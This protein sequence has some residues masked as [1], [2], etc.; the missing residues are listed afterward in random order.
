MSPSEIVWELISS[1]FQ[2]TE[3]WPAVVLCGVIVFGTFSLLSRFKQRRYQL[4]FLTAALGLIAT[5]F[6]LLMQWN[7]CW[8]YLL[9]AAL[10]LASLLL[11][12]VPFFWN[13][14]RFSKI[15]TLCR[16][17]FFAEAWKYLN[18]IRVTWLTSKQLRHY[19]QRRFFLLLKLGSLRTARNYLEEIFPEKGTNYHFFL[20]MLEYCSGD[21]RASLQEIQAAED[22]VDS[23]TTPSF[24][25]QILM[26]H[27]VCYAA[28][29]QYHLADEYYRKAKT[30]YDNQKLSDE[31]LL[32]TFYYNFA[33][34]QLRLH[35]DTTDW[36]DALNECQRQ[37]NMRKTDAKIRMLNLRLELLCQTE[38]PREVMDQLLQKA[39]TE[40][41]KCRLRPQ[42]Q[43]FFA[44]SAVRVA[45][46][47]RCNPIPCLDILLD[48]LS[49]IEGLSPEQ[50]YHVYAGLDEVFRDF[51]GPSNHR[52]TPLKLRAESYMKTDAE[53]DLQQWQAALPMEAVY[54]RCD[55]L[56]KRAVFSRQRTEYD[57]EQVVSFQQNAIRLYHDNG[58]YLEELH[59]HQDVV[60]ELLDVRNRNED[61]RPVCMEEIREHLSAAEA[62]LNK[63]EGHPA[64]VVAYLRLGCYYLDVDAYEQSL[65][66]A[67][68]FWNTDISVQN[69]APW[70][71]R[72]YA[73]L[74]LHARVILFEQ[75]IREAAADQQLRAMDNEVQDWF[76]TYPKHDGML[77]SL[78]LGRFLT[79]PVRKTKCWLPDANR[80][81]QGHSWLWIPALELNI[82]ITYPQFSDDKLC[83]CIFFFKDRHPFEAETSLTLQ[84]SYQNSSL[85]FEGVI[86]SQIENV[87]PPQA[88]LV[89]TI[90]DFI[91]S[92]LPNDCPSAASFAQLFQ[93]F[94]LP[95]P[96]KA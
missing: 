41:T 81:V 38:A 10:I 77:D 32:G 2:E 37:L 94:L 69:F 21:L 95:V 61:Y 87:L 22:S 33:F 76:A 72:Y 28:M 25:F 26:N 59:A 92:H 65:K 67:R 53:N 46:A 39:V 93:E 23:K 90:Y 36:D 17:Q 52:F 83:Q 86:C 31:E 74:L 55:C 80:E 24:R 6:N 64:L 85:R 18:S 20:H 71:R 84:I 48:K 16:Q 34:N 45:W 56:K 73:I 75:A 78:L 40:I 9:A 51:H 50:R 60:D 66:Y 49:V 43:V 54:A 13:K 1:K 12:F 70:L 58:L 5:E 29:N 8:L 15:Q 19:Q 68:L 14:K 89:D 47:A 11:F 3:F 91:C 79:V 62:L 57:R 82:D 42:K 7:D 88:A 44:S 35:P 4:G 30:F 27:G 63:L 96:I